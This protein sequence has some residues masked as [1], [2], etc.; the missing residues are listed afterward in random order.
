MA[1]N[2]ETKSITAPTFGSLTVNTIAVP[3]PSNAGPLYLI[4]DLFKMPQGTEDGTG[5]LSANRVGDKIHSLGFLMDY[6]FH[7]PTTYSL[8]AQFWLPFVKIRVLAFTISP[9]T[10]VP[11]ANLLFDTNILNTNTAT[12]QPINYS[13][14]YVKTVLYDKV[15]ILRSNNQSQGTVVFNK[16]SNVL[17][18]RK[19]IKYDRQIKYTDNLVSNPDQTNLP[20]M[21][22]ISCE[23]DDST[24]LVPS[25]QPL[26]Y[27]TGY[28]RGW[29]KDA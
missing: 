22:A 29:F 14:G 18:F 12:L 17:H 3:Y 4:Q 20:V 27:V 5:V 10:P 26:L 2:I 1:R 11:T 16:Y 15:H 19:Y 21:V 8:S 6:Y 13:A 28:S 25:G 7:M 24:A 23:L 9:N